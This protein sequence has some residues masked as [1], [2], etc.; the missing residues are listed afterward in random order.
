MSTLLLSGL[1]A[2]VFALW[3]VARIW[4][5]SPGLAVASFIFFPASLISL[6]RNWGDKESDIRLPFVLTA[7]AMGF[8]WHS[9]QGIAN[10]VFEDAASSDAPTSDDIQGTY[11]EGYTV[12]NLQCTPAR[13]DSYNCSYVVIMSEGREMPMDLNY[14]RAGNRW[15]VSDTK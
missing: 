2:G 12:K 8:W 3:T 14:A 9:M 6:F 15:R 11:M 5:S 10:S 1:L 7:V 4:R 13:G